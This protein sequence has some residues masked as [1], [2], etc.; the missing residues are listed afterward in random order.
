MVYSDFK[1]KNLSSLGLGCMRFPVTENK[2][3][4]ENAVREMVAYAMEKGINYYDTA[5][6]I[7]AVSPK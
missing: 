4:D 1:G 3:I 6:C 7:M 2:E 5:W